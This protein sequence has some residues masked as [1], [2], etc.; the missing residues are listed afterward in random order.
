MFNTRTRQEN[1][2]MLRVLSKR[3]NE[4]YMGKF[5]TNVEKK[6]GNSGFYLRAPY[7]QY[8]R[9]SFIREV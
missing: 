9:M 2:T 8:A 7:C 3:Q 5:Q 6:E 1:E 4:K